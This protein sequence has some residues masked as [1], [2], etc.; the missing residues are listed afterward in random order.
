MN[1][2]AEVAEQWRLGEQMRDPQRW[3]TRQIIAGRL[4]ARKVGRVWMMTQADISENLDR[5]AN[6]TPRREPSVGVPSLAS[7][8]RRR[9]A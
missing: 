4:R 9:S 5:L 7:M 3:L 1:T 6:A 8:R 2:L